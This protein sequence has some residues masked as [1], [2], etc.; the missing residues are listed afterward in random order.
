MKKIFPMA[1]IE[2]YGC[3][4]QLKVNKF[5]RVQS[6]LLLISNFKASSKVLDGVPI[7]IRNVINGAPGWLSQLGV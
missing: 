2:N 6:N 3:L 1:P 4:I 7:I 5:L